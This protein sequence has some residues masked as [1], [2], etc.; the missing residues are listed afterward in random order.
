MLLFLA[1]ECPVSNGYAPEYVRLAKEFGERGV[2]FWE[3]IP[4][5][6]LTAEVATQHGKEYGLTFAL[7]LDPQQELARATGVRVTPEAVVLTPAGRVPYRGRI[8]DRDAE[9]GKRRDEPRVRDL[10]DA[11]E[12]VL[13]DK[14]P[15]V[16]ETRA[17]GCPLPQR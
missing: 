9:D 16:A 11:I 1:T 15:P 17:F 5:P 3:C 6:D 7:L 4:I 14:A 10:H 2:L 8:D 13:A 12:A